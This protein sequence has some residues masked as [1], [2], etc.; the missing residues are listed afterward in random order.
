M[1]GQ[2]VG[3]VVESKHPEFK[4]GDKV[5]AARLAAFGVTKEGTEQA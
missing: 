4:P 3:E 1:V 2:T 5:L